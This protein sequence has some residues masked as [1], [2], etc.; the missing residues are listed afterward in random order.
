MRGGMTARNM[1]TSH[2]S[3]KQSLQPSEFNMQLLKIREKEDEVKRAIEASEYLL[4]MR[5]PASSRRLKEIS[6][7]ASRLPAGGDH[8][9]EESKS[10]AGILPKHIMSP[11]D[12]ATAHSMNIVDD[13]AAT[14]KPSKSPF[15][16][17][18]GAGGQSMP[19]MQAEL[20]S[21]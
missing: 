18:S 5:G 10:A 11:Y 14:S 12:M 8:I 21:L 20:A 17:T 9:I 6:T 2:S 3:A 1:G 13:T 7:A 16:T 15:S 19:A 4:K